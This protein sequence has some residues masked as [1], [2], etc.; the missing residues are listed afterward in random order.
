MNV[1]Y[2]NGAPTP[3]TEAAI[4]SIYMDR[5]GKKVYK[6]TFAYKTN[7]S[8][9]VFDWEEAAEMDYIPEPKNRAE[10]INEPKKKE[11]NGSS[12]QRQKNY[13]SYGKHTK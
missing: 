10:P 2:G 1:I 3:R 13:T 11:Q 7:I 9:S 6:C 4:G 5:V 8:S 12:Q